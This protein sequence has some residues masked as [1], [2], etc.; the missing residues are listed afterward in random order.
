MHWTDERREYLYKIRRRRSAAE[1]AEIM[2]DWYAE[3][4]TASEIDAFW[5][6][7]LD[8]GWLARKRKHKPKSKHPFAGENPEAEARRLKIATIMHLIDLKRAGHS[9]TRTEYVIS[10]EG[11]G[12][13]FATVQTSSFLGSAAATCVEHA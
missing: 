4:I 6:D 8:S 10:A 11:K 1:C 5:Q 12:V 7:M 9:P 13:K 2:S 3:E